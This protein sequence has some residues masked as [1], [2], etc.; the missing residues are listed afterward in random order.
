MI[1]I[2]WKL[3]ELRF[4]FFI[5]IIFFGIGSNYTKLIFFSTPIQEFDLIFSENF[6]VKQ[7]DYYVNAD[8]TIISNSIE[9]DIDTVTLNP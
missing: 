7:D 5:F 3:H 6:F 2:D 4:M 8:F 1:S 9:F